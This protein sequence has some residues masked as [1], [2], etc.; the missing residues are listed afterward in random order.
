M[1]FSAHLIGH[2]ANDGK[3]DKACINASETVANR[4]VECVPNFVFFEQ[5]I[6]WIR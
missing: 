6:K 4:D 3:D 5:L 1:N 2:E